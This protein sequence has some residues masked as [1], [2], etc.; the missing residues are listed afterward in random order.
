M[1]WK[2]KPSPAETA[3]AEACLHLRMISLGRTSYGASVT[4]VDLG[5]ARL[6]L[7]RLESLGMALVS[8]YDER[9][10]QTQWSEDRVRVE[11][12]RQNSS[13]ADDPSYRLFATKAV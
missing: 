8:Q 7:E 11:V 10:P 12:D 3:M 6:I 2:T 9:V 13:A 4:Q 5:H 1:L